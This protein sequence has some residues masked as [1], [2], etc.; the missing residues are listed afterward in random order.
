MHLLRT[1][2]RAVGAQGV[3]RCGERD[4]QVERHSSVCVRSGFIVEHKTKDV[5]YHSLAAAKSEAS[6]LAVQLSAQQEVVSKQRSSIE[7]L[8]ADKLATRA[9]RLRFDA[10][11]KMHDELEEANANLSR[12]LK[13]AK[14]GVE[15]LAVEKAELI[16]T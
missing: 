5:L 3:G 12:R 11:T 6:M 16:R 7:L 1:A 9:E 8:E 10:L 4:R 2:K 14:D 15:V 13:V